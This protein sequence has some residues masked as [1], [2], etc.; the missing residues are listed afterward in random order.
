[1]ANK[2]QAKTPK[3]AIHDPAR[4]LQQRENTGFKSK[5]LTSL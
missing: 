3:R 2:L 5:K 4:D 1:M